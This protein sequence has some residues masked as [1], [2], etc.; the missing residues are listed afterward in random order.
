MKTVIT[1]NAGV[2]LQLRISLFHVYV[3]NLGMQHACTV[4]MVT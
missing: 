3:Y 1:L 4:D 2:V